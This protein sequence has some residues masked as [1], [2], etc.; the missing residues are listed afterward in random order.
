MEIESFFVKFKH[1]LQ[2]GFNATL[3]MES[4]EG[5]AFVCLKAG[6]GNVKN[7]CTTDCSPNVQ[8]PKF[9]RYRSPSYRRWQ[10][11]RRRLFNATNNETTE[12]VEDIDI[13][14]TS[15]NAEDD[16]GEAE[17]VAGM[18]KYQTGID[19][20]NFSVLEANKQEADKASDVNVSNHGTTEFSCDLCN[21]TSSW[22]N[23][24]LLHMASIH[25]ETS[26]KLKSS[27]EVIKLTQSYWKTGRLQPNL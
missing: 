1:L 16:S 5:K 18:N 14:L 6:L 25:K 3:T 26:D 13:G 11:R 24:L 27:D 8:Q 21:F 2:A 23:G 7:P 12:N 9:I 15:N 10:E 4:R 22:S 17:E 20:A 19:T